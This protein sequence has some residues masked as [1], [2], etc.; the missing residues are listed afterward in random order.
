MALVRSA[1][2]ILASLNDQ[3][4]HVGTEQERRRPTQR[5]GMARRAL[6]P[7]QREIYELHVA[8]MGSGRIAIKLGRSRSTIY[9]QLSRARAK[10]DKFDLAPRAQ[11][12]YSL[13]C[14]GHTNQKIAGL[15]GVTVGTIHGYLATATAA[16][17]ALPRNTT[18]T[19]CGA[20]VA[21]KVNG[22]WTLRRAA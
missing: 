6:S 13:A 9:V 19:G 4:V 11:E 16:T 8:G 5:G 12:A 10:L 14:Q 17:G 21:V 15:M 2:A 7:M 20:P 22:M 3:S 1:A 18:S